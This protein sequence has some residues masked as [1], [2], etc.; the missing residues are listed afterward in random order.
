MPI[1]RPVQFFFGAIPWVLCLLGIGWLLFERFPPSG[2]FVAQTVLDGRSAWI[3]PFLPAQRTTSP[4]LQAEGW[5][6][7]RLTADPV[8]FT[9]RT[10]GPYQSVDVEL[11]FRAQKQPL[12]ELGIVRDAEGKELEMQPLYSSELASS[13]FR[14]VQDLGYVALGVPD[15]RLV[16]AKPEGLATWLATTSAMTPS[17]TGAVSKTYPLALR[18]SHDFYVIP[19]DGKIQVQLTL[20]AANRA[21]GGD[22]A[23]IRVF[24]GE[25]E[26]DRSAI[27]ISGSLD[28]RLSSKVERTIEIPAAIPGVYRVQVIASDEVF[29]RSI[30]TTSKHWVI[31]PRYIAGDQVGYATTTASVQVWTNSRHLVAETFHTEGLQQIKFGTA[32]GYLQRTHEQIRLDRSTD[33]EE[34]TT[35]IAPQG[36][37]RFIGDGFFAVSP[38]A[39]FEPRPRRL[40]DATDTSLD[41]ISAI[42]TAYIRPEEL[43]ND[44]KKQT[45]S[46]GLRPDQTNVR[47]VIS[48][49]GMAAR[50]AAVDIRSIRLIYH[51]EVGAWSSWW[52]ILRQEL[53]QAWKR[54]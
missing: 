16:D 22:I 23:A 33:V 46:F 39:F 52:S 31:G 35:L 9:A 25:E 5:V 26:L 38:E 50:A 27:G 11:E 28:Q 10:P 6:G 18:G 44:W 4:G 37:V 47:F 12:V 42:R 17:D 21:Q 40:T 32:R 19:V 54:L 34:I 51:R 29:I 3:Q 15:A 2:V 30:R 8:Y 49:P 48:A 43:G 20:Q 36:D 53:A 1:P 14:S 13:R 41:K 45:L 7:Q 24:R